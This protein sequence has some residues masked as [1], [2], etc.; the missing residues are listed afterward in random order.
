MND[1]NVIVMFEG[2]SVQVPCDDEMTVRDAI[3]E[4]GKA[5][6]GLPVD[7][8]RV[9]VKSASGEDGDDGVAHR[10]NHGIVLRPGCTVN[11]M[12]SRG[13]TADG[14]ALRAADAVAA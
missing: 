5:I 6:D 13:H 10:A 7:R 1:Q 3:R 14:A 9:T 11:V 4:A 8:F 2:A 12:R